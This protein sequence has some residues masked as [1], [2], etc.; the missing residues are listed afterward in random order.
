MSLSPD[1]PADA[2]LKLRSMA[3]WCKIEDALARRARWRAIAGQALCIT[4]WKP[5]RAY[6][7]AYLTMRSRLPTTYPA[8]PRASCLR[9]SRAGA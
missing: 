9:N 3:I 4:G 8:S 7:R 6:T 5:P 1:T 2:A